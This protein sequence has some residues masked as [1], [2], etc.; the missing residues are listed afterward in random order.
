M[1]STTR[2]IPAVLLSCTALAIA[3]LLT[4]PLYV[5]V[6]ILVISV[7][8]AVFRA[9]SVLPLTLTQLDSLMWAVLI[10]HTL[11]FLP[12]RDPRLLAQEQSA[13]PLIIFQVLIWF[14]VSLYSVFRIATNP[15]RLNTLLG[16]SARYAVL[17]FLLAAASSLYSVAPLIS[18][19]WSL[20]LLAILLGLSM[21]LNPAS[22][23]DATQR[24]LSSTL[25]GL[26][27]ML[28]GFVLLSLY[29]PESGIEHSRLTAV[30][31]LGGTLI[32]STKLAAVAGMISV[33]L[34]VGL[35][36]RRRLRTGLAYVL[37]VTCM[38]ASLG[39]G[40]ILATMASSILV[41]MYFRQ[42]VP[43]LS[44][45]LALL[46]VFVL[47]PTSIENSLELITRG[48][49]V[50]ELKSLTGRI[51]LWRASLDL[52]LERPVLGWGYVSGSRVALIEAFT[53]W[54][55]VDAHN[56]L[57][58]IVLTLGVV[59]A[60]ILMALLWTSSRTLLCLLSRHW[61][62]REEVALVSLK[63]GALLILLVVQG[64]FEGGFSSAPKF[65][66]AILLGIA[67]CSDMI[68]RETIQT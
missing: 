28:I 59:G 30:W 39:R 6:L 49:D 53:R 13:T 18:F 48:Q 41:L 12:G 34:L 5:T 22:P 54:P 42:A 38:L 35:L 16:P 43:A 21:L 25:L 8:L 64:I 31:R 56:A 11:A 62:S 27:L 61:G 29:S 45:F 4:S 7:G 60:C 66:T 19:V 17:F 23:L 20:K 15:T 67:M 33:V 68:Q 58:Q 14:I 10:G 1:T 63:L 36:H 2:Q 46:L 50:A 40:G 9:F 37:V 26:A 44:L 47:H 51:D 3:I 24:F 55:A 57:L 32:P 65:E 52:I